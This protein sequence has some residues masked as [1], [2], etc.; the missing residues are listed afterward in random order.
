V[1]GGG[2]REPRVDAVASEAAREGAA[3]GRARRPH[4]GARTEWKQRKGHTLIS[5]PSLAKM[6]ES[7]QQRCPNDVTT[8]QADSARVCVCAHFWPREASVLVYHLGD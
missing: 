3:K 6:R 2:S 1:C 5:S 8:M 4:L 7:A